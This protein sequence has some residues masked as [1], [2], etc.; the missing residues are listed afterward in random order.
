M[1]YYRFGACYITPPDSPYFSH[2]SFSDIQEQI[3]A[4]D[5]KVIILG[6]MNSRIPNLNTFN[7][8]QTGISFT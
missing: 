4:T 2:Q 1:P 8:M 5:D 3:S 7:N 6:D